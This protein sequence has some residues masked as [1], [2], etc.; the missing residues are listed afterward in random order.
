MIILQEFEEQSE[1]E[2]KDLEGKL[3]NQKLEDGEDD[4]ENGVDEDA[5]DKA[6]VPV[7][8][9]AFNKKKVRPSFNSLSTIL[10]S[11]IKCSETSSEVATRGV[12]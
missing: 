10:C 6:D 3:E 5:E 2:E 12:L 11:V 4:D 7:L 8:G 9:E 1:I